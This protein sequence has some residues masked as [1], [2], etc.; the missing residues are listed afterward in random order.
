[1]WPTAIHAMKI[2]PFCKL[3]NNMCILIKTWSIVKIL[4]TTE[5]G[6]LTGEKNTQEIRVKTSQN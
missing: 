3:K 4:I 1:M 2:K 6:I 5:L